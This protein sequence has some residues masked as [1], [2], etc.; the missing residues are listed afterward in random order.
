MDW[1]RIRALSLYILMFLISSSAHL[2]VTV[3]W[4]YAMFEGTTVCAELSFG[5]DNLAVICNC[6]QLCILGTSGTF[7]FLLKLELL[8]LKSK[9]SY[10]ELT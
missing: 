3:L 5:G 8:F 10:V 2:K 6:G 9:F 1:S 4:L 7:I